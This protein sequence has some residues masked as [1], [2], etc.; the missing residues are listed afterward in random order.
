MF[1]LIVC[2]EFNNEVHHQLRMYHNLVG[3]ATDYFYYAENL[4]VISD[5]LCVSFTES[6]LIVRRPYCHS[7][8]ILQF[9]KPSGDIKR[10][11]G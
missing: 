11:N 10:M 2:I 5:T 6:S 9:T 3:L 7:T 8:A 4:S 1:L